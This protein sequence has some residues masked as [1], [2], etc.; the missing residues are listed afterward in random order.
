MAFVQIGNLVRCILWRGVQHRNRDH[1]RK[2]PGDATGKEEIES[3]LVS[4]RFVHVGGCMPR[5]NR[6]GPSYGLIAA[7]EMSNVVIELAI[8]RERSHMDFIDGVAHAVSLIG[9]AM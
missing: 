9:R 2:S 5:V 1:R 7:G 3:N 8:R 4:S 6:R